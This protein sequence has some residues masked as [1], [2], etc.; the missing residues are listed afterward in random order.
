MIY[1]KKF[2]KRMTLKRWQIN[3]KKSWKK[4][5]RK[6]PNAMISNRVTG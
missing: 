4:C 1:V 5:T 3:W 6:L 2:S